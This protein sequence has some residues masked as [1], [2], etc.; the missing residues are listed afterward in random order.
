MMTHLPSRG[1]PDGEKF[2][3]NANGGGSW[4]II[5]Y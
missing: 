3:T 5:M 2:L 1:M 4:D